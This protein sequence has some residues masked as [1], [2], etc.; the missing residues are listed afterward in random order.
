M[1]TNGVVYQ[2]YSDIE[3]PNKMDDKPFFTFTMDAI[4]PGDIRTLEKFTKAAFDIDKIVQ[5]AGSLDP[6]RVIVGDA[7]SYCA[8]L[9][10]DNNRKTVAR[11]HFNG[12][13]TKYLGMFAGKDET[14]HLRSDLTHIYQYSAAIEARLRELDPAIPA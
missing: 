9:L 7:K 10:D 6:K 2:F 1:L 5:K 12:I 11:M 4:K 14:R 8:I 13:T 3:R